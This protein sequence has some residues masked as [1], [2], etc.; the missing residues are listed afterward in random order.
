[1]TFDLDF[2]LFQILPYISLA[3]LFLGSIVRFDRDPYSWRSKS[4]QLLRKRQL[5]WGSVLFHVGI[6]VILVGHAVG[7]LTPI[8]VF[9]ALGVSHS[10]KQVLAMTAGGIAGVFCLAGLLLLLHRR[11]FDPRIRANSSFADIAVLVLLLAQLCLGLMTITVSMHHLD[12]H[13]MVKFMEWA[14][15]VVT[16]RAGAAEFVRD[17]DVIFKLHL[18]LGMFIFIVFPFTRLVHIWSAP[19]FYLFRHQYQIVRRRES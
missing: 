6:L 14:Q 4:S 13:E 18:T 12:G 3:V 7:L 8:Q 10:F 1:M 11:L 16:F 15:H 17:V 5:M 2:F 19:V 9:D